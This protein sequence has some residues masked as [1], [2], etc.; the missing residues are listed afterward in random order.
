MASPMYNF[1]SLKE[2]TVIILCKVDDKNGIIIG[3]G[4]GEKGE[5]KAIV[6]LCD[7]NYPVAVKLGDCQIINMTKKWKKRLHVHHGD[8]G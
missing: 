6:A 3:F 8:G 7:S 5:P 2:G 1:G 4:P